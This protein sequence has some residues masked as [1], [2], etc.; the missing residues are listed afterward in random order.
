MSV[1]SRNLILLAA[2]AFVALSQTNLVCVCASGTIS[3]INAAMAKMIPEGKSS[4]EI[5]TSVKVFFTKMKLRQVPLAKEQSEALLIKLFQQKRI[6]D[7]VVKD[8]RTKVNVMRTNMHQ[9]SLRYISKV[10]YGDEKLGKSRR[11]RLSV[12]SL[13][14]EA[15]AK[16]E[17]DLEAKESQLKYIQGRIDQAKDVARNPVD[18]VAVPSNYGR[19]PPEEVQEREIDVLIEDRTRMDFRRQILEGSLSVSWMD[20]HF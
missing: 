7:D 5:K 4:E 3:S 19:E 10:D 15:L 17:A 20:D 11:P 6:L 1:P 14:E 16:A 18:Y 13:T 2:L 8:M 12:G 9:N